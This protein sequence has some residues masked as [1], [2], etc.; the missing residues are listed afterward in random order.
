MFDSGYPA[1]KKA[2]G[3]SPAAVAVKSGAEEGSIDLAT[4]KKILKDNPKSIYLV[5][6][7]DS[8]EFAAGHFKTAVNIP[9]DQLED[10]IN[11]LPT[12]KPIVFVCSTG[13]RSGESYYMLQDLKPDLKKVF[14]LEAEVEYSKDGSY[15]IKVVQ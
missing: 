11:S 6:V 9:V 13:A 5:D 1:W 14:Y 4:F 3:A 8:D 12:D 10:K 7:R 15:K 2:F